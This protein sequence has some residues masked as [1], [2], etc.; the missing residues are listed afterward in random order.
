MDGGVG[1]APMAGG[2]FLI[3]PDKGVYG[4]V[5]RLALEA[6]FDLTTGWNQCGAAPAWPRWHR[7]LFWQT[8]CET[9]APLIRENTWNYACSGTEQGLLYYYYNYCRPGYLCYHFPAFRHLAG[10]NRA[11]VLLADPALPALEPILLLKDRDMA[12][13]T[14]EQLAEEADVCARELEK[15]AVKKTEK[16]LVGA[17]A[18]AEQRGD[19]AA[20]TQIAKRLEALAKRLHN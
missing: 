18:E 5:T 12:G 9:I 16:E 10:N 7:G 14:P 11:E 20:A 6:Q 4:D 8:Y 17:L 2:N 13:W 19:R 15:T 3:K 1:H